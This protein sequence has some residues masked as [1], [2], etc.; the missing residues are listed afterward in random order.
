VRLSKRRMLD[1][2]MDLLDSPSL[3]LRK[4]KLK[5][6]H[7]NLHYDRHPETN[8]VINTKIVIDPRNSPVVS[9]VIH[10]LLHLY[11][12]KFHTI[13]KMFCEALE[14]AVVKGLTD[15]LEAYLHETKNERLFQSWVKT[16]EAKLK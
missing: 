16:V 3:Q 1:R 2:L 10:E 14:E 15:E 7:G 5:R 11:L 4:G 6:E 12:A 8:D 9:I 13:D